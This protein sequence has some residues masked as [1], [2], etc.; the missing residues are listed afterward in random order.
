MQ[1]SFNPS[2]PQNINLPRSPSSSNL[3]T[4]L[5]TN[6]SSL[7]TQKYVQTYQY[8]APQVPTQTPQYLSP[9]SAVNQLPNVN[10]RPYVISQPIPPNTKSNIIFKVDIHVQGVI[11]QGTIHQATTI[12]PS[13]PK[14]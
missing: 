4:T 5:P 9:G 2:P 3:P 11:P 7:P 1:P 13:A 14:P 6:P 8:N 10:N 12:A